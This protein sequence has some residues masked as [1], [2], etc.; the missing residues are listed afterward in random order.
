MAGIYIHIPF[1]RTRCH[2]CDFY[3]TTQLKRKPELVNALTRE[4]ELRKDWLQNEKI[5]TIYFG[6]GTPSL[7]LIEEVSQILDTIYKH[8]SIAKNAEITLEANPDD[9]TE[10]QI[11]LLAKTPLN[12]MSI[13]IQS[14]H[15]HQLQLMN[16]RHSA[17]DAVNAVKR[18]QDAGF[19]NLSVDL[20]YGLPESNLSLWEKSLEQV[21]AL[22]I[23]HVSA[24]HLTYEKG[25]VFDVKARQDKIIPCSEDESILQFRTLI[26]WAAQNDFIHYEISNFGRRGYFSQHNTSYWQQQKYLGIGPSAHSYNIESRTWNASNLSVYLDEIEKGKL[27]FEQEILSETDKFNEFLITSLRTRWG[28]NL[29]VLEKQFGQDKKE[30]LQQKA[31]PYIEGNKLYVRD[32]SLILTDEGVFVSD[33]VLAELMILPDENTD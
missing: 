2:Y 30:W 13:G 27:P 16:R 19:N 6:G 20:I 9:L 29:D 18:A 28:I 26:A 12:R 15:N 23:Q 17:Q 10:K 31:K 4:L 21:K 8:F 33:M 3:T 22:D 1:C 14:F 24:Y 5:Q 11:Q 25:T 7:L 32:N